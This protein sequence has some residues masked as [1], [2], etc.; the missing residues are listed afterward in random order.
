MGPTIAVEICAGDLE[1]ALAAGA[2]GADR[3]ELCDSLQVGGTTPSA[4]I[5]AEA[6]ARLS[7]PVHVLIRPRA[8]DFLYS[9][10]ELAAMRRDIDT[11]R[12]LG[13]AGVVLGMLRRDATI[14]RELTAALAD[15]A[16][17]LSVTFHKAFDQVRDPDEALETL[18]SLGVD[19]VLTSGGRPAA[20]EGIDVLRRLVQQ[21]RNR[22]AILAGG[23]LTLDVLPR[24]IAETGVREVHLGSAVAR[25]MAS[26][27]T[28]CPGD[29]LE[30]H[31]TGVDVA[32]VRT[33]VG[34]IREISGSPPENQ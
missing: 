23:C 4:G 17:P 34:R 7:I 2:G 8:G 9:E 19:R 31:R 32:R 13:A 22:I 3:V 10:A 25:P 27:M 30:L 6:C 12:S 33:I 21:S 20:V 5:I 26:A 24:L 16:R 18:I 29:D 1:S 28:S 14:D 11:A 15:R